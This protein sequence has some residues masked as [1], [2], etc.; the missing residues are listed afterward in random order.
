MEQPTP[1]KRHPSRKQSTTSK[2]PAAPTI[3]ERNAEHFH[4]YSDLIQ[5]WSTVASKEGGGELDNDIHPIFRQANFPHAEYEVLKRP[6]RLA[7]QLLEELAR[8]PF[9]KLLVKHGEFIKITDG[10]KTEYAYPPLQTAEL[11]EQD[12]SDIQQAL[13]RL[14]ELVTF[15]KDDEL[16]SSSART[17]PMVRPAGFVPV[18][19]R[20]VPSTI[21]YS[22]RAYEQLRKLANPKSKDVVART[23]HEFNF[24]VTLMHESVHALVNAVDGGIDYEPF[25]STD[26][27]KAPISEVGFAAEVELFGGHIAMLFDIRHCV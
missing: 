21:F 6:L 7:S 24:A 18:L 9:M 16:S 11:T 19:P 10:D 13:A 3:S 23:V 25:M 4:R 15:R 17:E 20:E 27:N 26:S 2:K 1:R 14:A 12:K 8:R 22:K 5:V